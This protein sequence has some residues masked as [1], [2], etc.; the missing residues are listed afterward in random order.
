MNRL[1]TELN[2]IDAAVG[3]LN[4]VALVPLYSFVWGKI[5]IVGLCRLVAFSFISEI[6]NFTF[7][8]WW[9]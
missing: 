9:L 6:A 4:A 5:K 8:R 7:E 1:K 3:K 2:T